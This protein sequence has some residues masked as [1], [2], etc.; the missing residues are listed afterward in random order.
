MGSVVSEGTTETTGDTLNC[1]R[2]DDLLKLLL[3]VVLLVNVVLLNDVLD[4]LLLCLG[5]D[6]TT[7]TEE[8]WQLVVFNW[9]LLLLLLLPQFYLFLSFSSVLRVSVP[10]M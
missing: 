1:N 2:L 4:D 9:F 5:G 10:H 7:L 3:A 8:C 6:V